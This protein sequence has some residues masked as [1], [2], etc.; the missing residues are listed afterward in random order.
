MADHEA[1]QHATAALE[2]RQVQ[3]RQEVL[4]GQ[5]LKKV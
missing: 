4:V 1:Q 2:A 5:G 3:L